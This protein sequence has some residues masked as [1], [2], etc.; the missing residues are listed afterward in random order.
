MIDEHV[1]RKSYSERPALWEFVTEPER[2]GHAGLPRRYT[3]QILVPSAWETLPG[4]ENYRGKAWLRSA[5]PGAPKGRA[6]RIVFGG[7]SH[8]A[9]VFIDGKLVGQHYDA[10]TPFEVL[11]PGKGKGMPHEIVVEV[12]NSFGEH[13]ALHLENDYYTYGGITRPMKI[14]Q[15]PPVF[16]ERLHATPR[17]K[18]KDWLLDVVV[19]L[20]NWSAE[21]HRYNVRVCGGDF[22]P[23]STDLGIVAVAAG[24]RAEVR[25]TLSAPGVEPW[26]PESPVLYD[27]R[28]F[29]VDE[30]IASR[31]ADGVPHRDLDELGDRIGF[32][33]VKVRGKQI[34][35]NGK[36]IRFRG[37][38]RHEDHPQFGCAIPVEAMMTDLQLLRDLGCNFV[39]TSHYPNDMRFLDLCD[40]LGILVWEESHS[41]STPF[42]HPKFHEQILTNT[43]EMVDWHRNHPSIIIWGSL[44]ECESQQ[45]ESVDTVAAVLGLLKQLD[46]SR[47]VTFATMYAKRDLCL[48]LVDIVSFNLYEG[49]YGGQPET[50]GV[51]LKELLGWLHTDASKGGKGKPVIVSE[52]GGAA[53]YGNRQPRATKWSEEYQARLLDEAL[54]V[55]L[56]HAEVSGAAI[57]QFCDCRITPGHA[58]WGT[59]PR[60]MNNKG[61]VDEYR[62]PKLAYEAVQRRM[63]EAAAKWDAKPA[64]AVKKSRR[65]HA[66]A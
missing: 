48:G 25:A 39:R 54:R 18:G 21:P 24:A 44:N 6:L 5:V 15:V 60:T 22:L 64:A 56:N 10:F 14:Q 49:W 47:P 43:A 9:R 13:S 65:K 50:I 38:N 33:E 52:F 2:T 57:W 51:R 7:V 58:H 3:R 29:A 53:L 66:E 36:P 61:T 34:L 16:V 30:A 12:D 20:R 46:P 27:V 35:L 8:T 63:R 59:R 28:V 55:Y 19:R 42:K 62:R 41:R 1:Y 11:V 32:R 26:S 40:E 31:D 17:R 23:P 4:L 37:Y 45:P